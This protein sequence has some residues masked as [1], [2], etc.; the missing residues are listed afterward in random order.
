[1]TRFTARSDDRAQHTR[2]MKITEKLL[3]VFAFVW[4]LL[5]GLSILVGL[6]GIWWKSGLGEVQRIF[7]PFNL[8]NLG[9]IVLLSLP[10]VGATVLADR[11]LLRSKTRRGSPAPHL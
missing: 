8:I 9:L 5:V 6:I 10:A 2:Y 11:I 1:V 7:S 4:G 3:R